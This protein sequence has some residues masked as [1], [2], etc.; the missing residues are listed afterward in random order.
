MPPSVN[1]LSSARNKKLTTFPRMQYARPRS[2][3]FRFLTGGRTLGV[4]PVAVPFFSVFAASFLQAGHYLGTVRSAS[5]L[6]M[7]TH[8]DVPERRFSLFFDFGFYF[9]N[10]ARGQQFP[11]R[12]RGKFYLSSGGDEASG[13]CRSRSRSGDQ[14]TPIAAQN[15][16]TGACGCERSG[17]PVYRQH[18][19]RTKE[20]D[21]RSAARHRVGVWNEDVGFIAEGEALKSLP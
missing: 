12:V 5:L 1:T 17:Y 14:T 8:E 3:D 16:A 19:E 9:R 6:P 2:D 13:A 7:N 20:S 11:K 10:R 18:R 21:V 15:D 4:V